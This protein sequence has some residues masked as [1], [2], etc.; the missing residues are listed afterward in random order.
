MGKV[1]AERREIL[2]AAIA[3][4]LSTGKGRV[5]GRGDFHVVIVRPFGKRMMISV[6][7]EGN[8]HHSSPNTFDLQSKLYVFG[9]VGTRTWIGLATVLILV[10]AI[11]LIG[12]LAS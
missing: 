4:A 9:E 2:S 6:D 1:A 10:L 11:V 3:R 5:E 7:E 8:V 12:A